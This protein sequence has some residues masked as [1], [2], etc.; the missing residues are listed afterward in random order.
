MLFGNDKVLFS[1]LYI[2]PSHPWSDVDIT[3]LLDF[4]RKC[5]L[6]SIHYGTDILQNERT[7]RRNM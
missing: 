2:S 7:V 6:L 1:A 3:E 5:I 4:K